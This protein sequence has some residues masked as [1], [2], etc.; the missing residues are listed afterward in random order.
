MKIISKHKDYFDSALSYGGHEDNSL[1][2]KRKSEDVRVTVTEIFGDRCP[3][4]EMSGHS[5]MRWL[6]SG[7]RDK[8]VS[9]LFD[10]GIIIFCAKA[11][12]YA[13]L[14]VENAV[15]WGVKPHQ[16]QEVEQILM[17]NAV[18]VGLFD[19][20]LTFYTLE[21]AMKLIQSLAKYFCFNESQV[22]E[23]EVLF[24][25]FCKNFGGS[26][27]FDGDSVHRKFG[28][29]YMMVP[30]TYYGIS[31]REPVDVV[32]NPI[33]KEFQFAKVVE[34]CLAF[35]EIEMY[36]SGVMG[37][38][39]K[40]MIEISDEDKRDAKGFDDWSFKKMKSKR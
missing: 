22:D 17:Q 21:S 6:R 14:K 40:P 23:F 29:P 10:F 2:F 20:R 15:R 7:Y 9:G 11:Y 1:I 25:D 33:L 28:V 36:L 18:K 8:G 16:K 27:Y 13:Q 30:V 19:H 26:R 34:P 39:D 12:P 24:D 31:N 5:S 4:L 32:L 37:A 35:Q 3:P 38:G